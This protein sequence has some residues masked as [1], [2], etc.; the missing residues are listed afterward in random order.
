MRY[1]NR[2]CTN[3]YSAIICQSNEQI[4]SELGMFNIFCWDSLFYNFY[5]LRPFLI[6]VLHFLLFIHCYREFFIE[7]V[8]LLVRKS[9]MWNLIKN[10]SAGKSSQLLFHLVNFLC[11]LFENL[12]MNWSWFDLLMWIK[13]LLI[14]PFVHVDLL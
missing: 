11:W 6:L 14:F 2:R 1:L 7:F 4:K 9:W 8:F 3:F 5:I 10:K 13:N 12:R